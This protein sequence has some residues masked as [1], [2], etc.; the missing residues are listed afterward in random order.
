VEKGML[1]TKL[2]VKIEVELEVES[3]SRRRKC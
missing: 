1:K 2:A 3:G